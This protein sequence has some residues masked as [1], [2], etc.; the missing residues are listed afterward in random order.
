MS[1]YVQIYNEVWR[2][3][4]S[5]FC[6]CAFS[7]IVFPTVEV[8]LLQ[9]IFSWAWKVKTAPPTSNRLSGWKQLSWTL[10]HVRSKPREALWTVEMRSASKQTYTYFH[11]TCGPRGSR[12]SSYWPSRRER[13]NSRVLQ[14]H[15]RT[16]A[17]L[18]ARFQLPRVQQS[19]AGSHY[20]HL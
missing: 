6:V 11:P 17:C 15:K 7:F 10:P 12:D 2:L 9:M 18:A 4:C 20:K 1:W 13:D 14:M 5:L 3:Y 8:M 19:Q 16:V